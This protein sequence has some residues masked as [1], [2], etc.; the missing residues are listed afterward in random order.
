MAA[1]ASWQPSLSL[2]QD[3][4]SVYTYTFSSG[5]NNNKTSE[6]Q[7]RAGLGLVG[8]RQSYNRED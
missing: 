6:G 4:Y 3:S 1:T 2:K 5:G 7:R 8:R